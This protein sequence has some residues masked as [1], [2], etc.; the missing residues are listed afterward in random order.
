LSEELAAI[1]RLLAEEQFVEPFGRAAD[2]AG[3]VVNA[4]SGDID[5]PSLRDVIPGHT[6]IT[7]STHIPGPRDPLHAQVVELKTDRRAG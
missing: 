1:N 7:W 4:C 5:V 2:T 6:P 3:P